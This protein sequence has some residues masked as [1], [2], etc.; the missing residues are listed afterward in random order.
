MQ[1]PCGPVAEVMGRAGFSWVAVDLE[2]GAF[3]RATLDDIFRALELGG[4]VPFARV[5][6]KTRKEIREAVDAGARGIIVPMVDS[7]GD[8]EEA[9][10][11]VKYPPKGTRGVGYSRANLFGKRFGEYFRSFNANV[12]TVAQIESIGAVERLPEILSVPG[13]DAI[14]VGPYDLSASMNLV[15]QFE[16]REF[17]KAMARARSAARRAGVAMGV[18]IV[19]PNKEALDQRIR[20]G[21]QF[22]AYGIDAVFLYE[23]A[24]NPKSQAAKAV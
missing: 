10:S 24:V 23:N 20:E 3:S 19:H 11:W 6:Q 21:Y 12:V 17:K 9:L 18:H 8:L 13:V 7:K 22:I 15:G 4:T 14:M 2:H 1:F 16:S 5:A